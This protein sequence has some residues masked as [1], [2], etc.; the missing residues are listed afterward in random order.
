MP[1]DLGRPFARENILDNIAVAMAHPSCVVGLLTGG[2]VEGL[3]RILDAVL[4]ELSKTDP[5][6]IKHALIASGNEKVLRLPKKLHRFD[7]S[8]A[9][10]N[11]VLLYYLIRDSKPEC[12]LETGVWTGKSS[13]AIL[14]ALHDNQKGKLVSID[15]GL[16]SYY[17]QGTTRKLP[18]AN[19]G[20][21]V[22]KPLR[23]RWELILGDSKLIL[24][25]L[26]KKLGAID[27]FY[28]DSDYSYEG[29]MFEFES[30]FSFV[31]K[32]GILSSDSVRLSN[33][34]NDFSSKFCDSSVVHNRFGWGYK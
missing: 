22:P 23:S 30:V 4:E 5:T 1:F 34:W 11:L 33:V 9:L 16:T 10:A 21:M 28:H 20:D 31:P 13:W 2:R 26:L 7:N 12:V 18:I 6:E 27:V 8:A 15:R 32:G 3:R 17:E 14:K 29:M 25:S 19:I 24:P